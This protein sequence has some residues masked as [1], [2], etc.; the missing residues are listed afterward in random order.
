MITNGGHLGSVVG[1]SNLDSDGSVQT[2]EI[3]NGI[4]DGGSF[5]VER[6]DENRKSFEIRADESRKVR[7]HHQCTV[8]AQIRDLQC[9][10]PLG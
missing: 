5:V 2:A 1:S 8:I 4:D 7:H 9:S 6:L 10:E 3:E